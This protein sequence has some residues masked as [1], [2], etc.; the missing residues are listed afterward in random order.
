MDSAAQAYIER[1]HE[2]PGF[3]GPLDAALFARLFEVQDDAGVGG[4]VLEIG[5]WYGRSAILLE[6]LK[7]ERDVLHVCDLFEDTPPTRAGRME[8]AAF[9]GQM[10]TRADFE[11]WF[12]SYHPGLPTIHQGPSSA[13]SAR[14][15]GS[16]RFRFVHVDGSHTYEA[17]TQDISIACE[18]ATEGGVL[19]FDDFANVGHP[20]V[21]AAL[22]PAIMQSDFEPF[23]SSPSK[24]YVTL[25][26][27]RA[28]QYRVA[29]EELAGQHGHRW[30]VSELPDEG[31]ILT[32]WPI[33]ERRGLGARVAGRVRRSIRRTL[34]R[35]PSALAAHR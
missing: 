2:V 17:V 4:G 21:A 9:R 15:L 12:R 8:L 24:L 7:G 22:W 6:Y 5:C 23:A 10:P 13:L 34:S 35:A 11:A 29:I 18:I 25:G 3:F 16:N 1:M 33:N 19:V 26:S 30:K 32:V 14:E 20:G 28:A 31:A 27:D